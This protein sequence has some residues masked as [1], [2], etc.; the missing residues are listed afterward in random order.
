MVDTH[1]LFTG[2][3]SLLQKA[4][5]QHSEVDILPSMSRFESPVSLPPDELVKLHRSLL[6]VS[7]LF[8]V[9]RTNVPYKELMMN[10]TPFLVRAI[11]SPTRIMWQQTKPLGGNP[12]FFEM[13]FLLTRSKILL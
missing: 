10:Q 9:C 5:S 1:T 11:V 8:W 2:S 4:P 12:C 13:S 3:N 7:A 6:S